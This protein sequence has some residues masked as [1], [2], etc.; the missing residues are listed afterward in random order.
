VI[1]DPCHY[2][3][4]DIRGRGA[5][6]I[7]LYIRL[8]VLLGAI[9]LAANSP[10]LA[11]TTLRRASAAAKEA[12]ALSLWGRADETDED[13]FWGFVQHRIQKAAFNDDVRRCMRRDLAGLAIKLGM[14]CD[15][16]VVP[17]APNRSGP[18]LD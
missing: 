11:V 5:A 6:R 7:Y 1:F 9:Q 13:N 12:P 15:R 4:R 3:P 16:Q 14:L 17:T 18:Q 10:I 2:P 8:S